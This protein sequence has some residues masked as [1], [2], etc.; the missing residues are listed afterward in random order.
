MILPFRKNQLEQQLN[1]AETYDEWRQAAHQYDLD[2]GLDDWR[3]TEAS[4]YF[5]YRAIRRRLESLRRLRKQADD[6]GLLF[7]LNEGIHG[8]QG[9]IANP[10]L[11]NKC[12]SGTKHL[13]D[14]FIHELTEALHD[15]AASDEISLQ[16]K[17]EFFARASHCFGC[18]ALM[19]SGGA[20]LG[21]FHVG[22]I[23]SLL[24]QNL[25]PDVI[26]GS[27]AGSLIASV[28]CTHSEQELEQV[29]TIENIVG[30][31]KV[32]SRGKN[33]FGG[34]GLVDEKTLRDDIV[35]RMV[36]DLT[37]EEA[38]NKTGRKLNI[39]VTGAGQH[40]ASR[41]LNAITSPHV[42]IR[43]AVMASCAVVG[44]FPAVS[45]VAKDIDGNEVPYLPELSWVD[46]SFSDDLPA[47]RLGRLY[48]VNHYIA[49]M[50]NPVVLPFGRN[51]DAR[52]SQL[53]ELIDIP[54]KL[55]RQASGDVLKLGRHYMPMR[56][57]MLGR[58]QQLAHGVIAQDYT[59]D[60]NIM[61]SRK[62]FNPLTLL[63]QKEPKEVAAYIRDGEKQ[64]WQKIEM[65]RNC[66]AISRALAQIES[67]LESV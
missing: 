59:A 17:Q 54:I 52:R 13:I 42:C 32:R 25:L 39:T 19:L 49:S 47:K 34:R 55:C 2:E 5:D 31:A 44:V 48:G 18:S 36:P 58:L 56:N 9:G 16:E 57:T 27:S 67:E 43:S 61:P 15:V 41:L 12:K 51:P 37:F 22:V 64:A 23:Q 45:L 38:F 40:Q 1:Q 33:L 66:T 50:V 35:N 46:G 21:H 53:S 10:A 20:S 6:R 28:L 11:Y 26:S 14:E 63:N 65:I 3:A 60:I 8:N 30:S 29:F 4:R 7:E 24:G 62:L